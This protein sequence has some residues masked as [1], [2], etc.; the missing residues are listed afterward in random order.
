MPKRKQNIRQAIETPLLGFI[1][2]ILALMCLL[3]LLA[4]LI[5]AVR[6]V[7]G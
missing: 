7:M 1:V 2:I 5:V 3:L 4:G 6:V